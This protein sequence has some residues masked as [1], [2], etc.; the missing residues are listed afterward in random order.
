MHKGGTLT[1]AQSTETSASTA[2]Q[3]ATAKQA[4][5]NLSVPEAKPAAHR[6]AQALNGQ[7]RAQ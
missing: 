6:V 2:A 1:A 5:G 4:P 3:A 7:F